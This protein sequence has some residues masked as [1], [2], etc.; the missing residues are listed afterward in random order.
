MF[1]VALALIFPNSFLRL[2]EMLLCN[3]H[4]WINTIIIGQWW[5]FHQIQKSQI[6]I[7]IVCVKFFEKYSAVMHFVKK[8]QR[9]K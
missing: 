7:T 1:S 9:K 6:S 5:F 3:V 2:Y 4:W 8:V